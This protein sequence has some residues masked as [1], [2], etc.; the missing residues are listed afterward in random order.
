MVSNKNGEGMSKKVPSR[1][2]E[3]SINF[4][5]HFCQHDGFFNHHNGVLEIHYFIAHENSHDMYISNSHSR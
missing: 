3:I 4:V 2:F 5:F 1:I